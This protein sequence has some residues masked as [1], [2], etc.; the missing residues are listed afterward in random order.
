MNPE[1]K[2]QDGDIAEA[3]AV[4]Q[5]MTNGYWVTQIIYVA[6][7]LG[8]A[9]LLTD[10]PRTIQELAR[11]TTTHAPSLYRL[12]RALA[13]L[14]VFRESEDGTFET[15]TLGRCLVSGSPGALRAR[16]IVN[17]EEWYRAWGGLL[18]SV[19]TGETAFDHIFGMPLFEYLSAN[20]GAAAIFNEAMAS[21]TELA[22][23]AVA[24]AYDLSAGRDDRRRGRWN[25]R[26]PRRHP[27]GQPAGA[28]HPLRPAGRRRAAP[29]RFSPAPAWRTGARWSRETSSSRCRA[30][31]ASTSCPGSS[32][33]GTTTAR[34]TIL[35]NCRR[36]MARRR[37]APHHRAG[38]PAAA[39]SHRSASC[40]ISRCSCC[41]EAVSAVRT[42]IGP[43]S[44]QPTSRSPGSSRPGSLEA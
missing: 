25:R 41:P 11:S 8:I 30:A 44:R 16:A 32:M 13:G 33:T 15:T 21:S 35:K 17:G 9:D 36:A 22:A 4:L 2:P 12:M 40:T 39:T 20:A 38:S 26:V 19:R 10:G 34:V 42:S 1:G 27:D 6:A 14:G 5:Q 7:K 31:E 18:H 3:Q 28:R 37:A 23:R 29:A 24:E 43:F